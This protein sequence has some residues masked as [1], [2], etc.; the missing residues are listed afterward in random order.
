[1]D[2]AGKPINLKS[3]LGNGGLEPLV[4]VDISEVLGWFAI[5]S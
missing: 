1:M 5:E 2:P 3:L 4:L